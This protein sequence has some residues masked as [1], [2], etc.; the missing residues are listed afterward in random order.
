MKKI[1]LI[2][3]LLFVT[4]LMVITLSLETAVAQDTTLFDTDPGLLVSPVLNEVIIMANPDGEAP[5]PIAAPARAISPNAVQSATF[6]VNYIDKA[7]TWDLNPGAEAAFQYAVDIWAS[8]VYSPVPITIDAYWMPLEPNVLGSAGTRHIVHSQPSFPQSN[9]YYPIALANAF[10]GY[11]FVVSHS[12]IRARF[13]SDFDWYFGTDNNTPS[14]KY[15]FATVVLHEI[16]HGLGFAG[17]MYW[18]CRFV[19]NEGCWGFTGSDEIIR[20]F[21]YDRFTESNSGISLLNTSVFPNPSIQLGQQLTSN[22]IYFD[23]TYSREKN[24]GGRIPLY[25]P[26]SW[27]SGSSYSHLADSYDFTEN[28]LMTHSLAPGETIY[29]PGPVTLGM[30]KDLGWNVYFPA[31]LSDLPTQLLE[32][33]TQI[34]NAINLTDYT[35]RQPGFSYSISYDLTD[36]GDSGAGIQFDGVNISINPQTDWTGKTTVTAEVTDQSNDPSTSTFTVVVAEE[37][38]NVYLPAIIK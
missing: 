29:H 18:E 5:P 15:N 38:Q 19:P 28:A 7:T 1:R 4:T 12:D 27:N 9:T 36:Y 31:E 10:A 32:K 34:T 21:V 11:D 2:A 24:D 14:G 26:S 16:S 22:S 33:D 37:I 30:F 25:A 8:L 20:P 13:N 17:S 23:G 3:G 6:Q 35:I